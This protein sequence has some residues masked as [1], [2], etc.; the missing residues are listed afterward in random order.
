MSPVEP[1]SEVR[2]TRG[3]LS[4]R[5]DCC[6][7]FAFLIRRVRPRGITESDAAKRSRVAGIHERNEKKETLWIRFFPRSG[8]LCSSHQERKSPEHLN[9]KVTVRIGFENS[10]PY[11]ERMRFEF[12]SNSFSL[13]DSAAYESHD[14]DLIQLCVLD[15]ITDFHY[16]KERCL[17][18]SRIV[19]A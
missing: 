3:P 15:S 4:K 16:E 14:E 12:T 13:M 11:R 8:R 17:D 18:S 7:I 9:S 6:H 1:G 5:T 2:E 19:S 10:F